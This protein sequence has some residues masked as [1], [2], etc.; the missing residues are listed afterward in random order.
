MSNF[1]KREQIVILIFVIIV[2]LGYKIYM[3][4]DLELIKADTNLEDN[5]IISSKITN[6]DNENVKNEI[7]EGSPNKIIVHIDGEVINPGVIELNE[8]ARIIDAVNIAGGLT[9]YADEKRINL[10]KKVQDEEKI[11]IPKVGEDVSDLETTF[12]NHDSPN[13][14]KVNINT[15]T[16]EELQSLSGIGPVLAERIIEYRQNHKFSNID[17]IKKVAGIGDKKFES[18]KDFIVVK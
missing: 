16:K 7:E 14:G 6:L 8:G 4:K 18:I 2:A 15:A 9:Q 10:A 5:E 17:D 1:T 13:Q 12:V 3:K 11:Y